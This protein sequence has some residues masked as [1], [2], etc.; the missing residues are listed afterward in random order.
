MTESLLTRKV[1]SIYDM[2]AKSMVN[3][4]ERDNLVHRLESNIN[5]RGVRGGQFKFLFE[6][7]KNKLEQVSLNKTSAQLV[8]APPSFFKDANYPHILHG[9]SQD[10]FLPKPLP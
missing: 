9:V 2:E 8:S 7:G 3:K 5:S 6:A 1:K 4:R 10:I